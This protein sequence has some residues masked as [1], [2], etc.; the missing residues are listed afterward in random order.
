MAKFGMGLTELELHLNQ[1]PLGL[2][3]LMPQRRA[4]LRLANSL[5]SRLAAATGQV[6]LEDLGDSR[7]ELLRQGQSLA[8]GTSISR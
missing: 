4:L 7:R 5:T 1:L 8:L 2:G 3:Q 6:G